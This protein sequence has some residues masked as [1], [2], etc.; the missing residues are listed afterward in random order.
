MP[1]ITLSKKGL[2]KSI[3]KRLPDKEL[4]ERISMLGTDL[5]GIDGDDINVEIFPNRPDLLSQEGFARAFG[6]FLGVKTGLR[7]YE[8][9]KSGE[10]CIV[11]RSVATC[12]PY[13]ACAIV[14]G[15]KIN[16]ERLKEIIRVQEKLHITFCRNRKRAAIGIY[17][18]ESIA[19]PVRF[20]G[21]K[22]AE[23]K[24][25]P[26]EARGEMTAKQILE[27]HPKGKEYAHLLAGLD[28]YACFVDGD[29][30]IMSLTPIINSHLTGKI[31]AS[32]KDVFIE[33]S[34][35][36][37]RILDEC[38]AMVVT[39]LADMGGTIHSMDLVYP[40]K[41]IVRP[42]L[43]PSRMKVDRKYINGLLGLDLDEN[44]LKKLLGRMGYGYE[45]G[46]ALVPAYRTD[47][48]HQA[49]LAEDVAIAYGYD[50][51]P[52][53]IPAVATIAQASPSAVFAETVRALL[54][55]HGLLECKS[56]NLINSDVQT[57][58][59][60]L[61]AMDVVT[62]KNP[63][64]LEYDALR[65]W[66]LPSLI[67]TLQR[68]KRHEYPQRIFEIG[69][70]FAKDG[71]TETG[72][73]EKERLAITLCGEDADYTAIRQLL[74]D[75][76]AKLGLQGTYKETAHASFIPGR[77][78]RVS[79]GKEAV[80]YIGELAPAVLA[81]FELTM[82]VACCELDLSTLQK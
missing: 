72:V 10:K 35:F 44:A 14:R 18:L 6:A 33:C 16:E 68:N 42:D 11:D 52:E 5:E 15:L 48:L 23:I 45:K 66:V 74:D 12:R 20:K 2:L 75:L 36:D 30:A 38:L 50:R 54:A 71:K 46:T 26:L 13:T 51:I 29:G 9:R 64:S 78:A 47:L 49:D 39:A 28:R 27:E 59:M 69:R 22:P 1:T 73:R 17:P 21:L 76:L 56:Y 70:V 55:G 80:A 4:K 79:V 53:T 63:V 32:T 81:N 40:T 57:A 31:S 67:E 37:Q 41:K 24:F 43:A 62:L 3:G 65:A 58:K 34:G 19:F 77:V 7:K 8:V 82:P 61:D 25:R 60:G